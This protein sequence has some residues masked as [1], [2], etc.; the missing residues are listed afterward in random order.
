MSSKAA[1]YDAKAEKTSLTF[2]RKLLVIDRLKDQNDATRTFLKQMSSKRQEVDGQED[3]QRQEE[4]RGA[5]HHTHAY[6]LGE[7]GRGRGR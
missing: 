4:V 2:D 6:D 1:F 3:R 5:A 7:L